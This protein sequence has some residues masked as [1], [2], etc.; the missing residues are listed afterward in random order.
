MKSKWLRLLLKLGNGKFLR[1]TSKF[2][3]SSNN[4]NY[5]RRRSIISRRVLFAQLDQIRIQLKTWSTPWWI[6]VMRKWRLSSSRI[7]GSTSR[8]SRKAT[9]MMEIIWFG[10]SKSKERNNWMSKPKSSRTESLDLILMVG[11]L[12]VALVVIHREI[13]F[14]QVRLHFRLKRRRSGREWSSV[15]ISEKEMQPQRTFGMAIIIRITYSKGVRKSLIMK[16]KVM[17][18][19]IRMNS[20]RSCLCSQAIACNRF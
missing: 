10:N 15:Q 18:Q 14:Q 9:T 5:S 4:R 19:M 16:T 1:A 13:P 3:Q 20:R 12:F 17:T 7:S 8:R 11:L 2:M 6:A